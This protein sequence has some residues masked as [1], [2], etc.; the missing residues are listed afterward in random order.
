VDVL[1]RDLLLTLAPVPI[2]ATPMLRS[3][4]LAQRWS[5]P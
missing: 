3:A 2:N 1:D 4:R 5:W